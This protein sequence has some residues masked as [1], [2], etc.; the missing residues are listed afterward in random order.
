MFGAFL[1]VSPFP[2]LF[3]ALVCFMAPKCKSTP[4]RNPLRSGASSSSSPSDPTPSHVRFRDDKAR[5]DFSKN[6]SRRGIHSERQV[7]LTDFS[8][9]DLPL[10]SIIG[11]GSNCVASRSLVWHPGHLSLHDHTRVLLQYARFRLFS[12]SFCHWCL[13]Y[14]HC[15]YSGY[16]IQGTIC[17]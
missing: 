17:S 9:T 13:R 12:T 14:A 10:S 11:V 1:H 16:C 15:S 3:L 2:S 6:F 7:V 5:K 8:D 4:S